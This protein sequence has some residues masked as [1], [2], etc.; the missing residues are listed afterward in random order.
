M[1]K[2]ACNCG[3]LGKWVYIP[4]TDQK[5]NRYFCD[6]CVHRGCSCET[7]YVEY[8]FIPPSDTNNWIWK[9]KDKS[10]CY[11]DDLG[12]EYPCCEFWFYQEGDEATDEDIEYFK[13]KN[14]EYKI[15]NEE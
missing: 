13:S 6:D 4:S 5:Y 15:I 8:G 7:Y 14:I 10:W 11:I 3:K 12:R 2:F 9:V 1:R